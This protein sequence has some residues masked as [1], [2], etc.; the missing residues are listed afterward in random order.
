MSLKITR[1]SEKS[2]GVAPV[3]LATLLYRAFNVTWCVW[4]NSHKILQQERRWQQ[5]E[6]CRKQQKAWANFHKKYHLDKFAFLKILDLE[7]P[8][9]IATSAAVGE[10]NTINFG[11]DYRKT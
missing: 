1:S 10:K 6:I 2:L 7:G 3:I 5:K 8:L 4:R 11:L 9:V